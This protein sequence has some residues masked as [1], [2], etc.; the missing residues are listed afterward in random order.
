MD[1][2]LIHMDIHSDIHLDI[3]VHIHLDIQAFPK[4]KS[5]CISNLILLDIQCL[6]HTFSKHIQLVIHV[7]V[8]PT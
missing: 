4:G 3:H 8:Y 5:M 2:Y 1:K 7:M 6:S